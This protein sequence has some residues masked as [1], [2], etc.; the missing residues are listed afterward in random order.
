MAIDAIT[1]IKVKPFV[2][3]YLENLDN[4]S[5][6]LSNIEYNYKG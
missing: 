3:K 4:E 1:S 5:I 6:L 2:L